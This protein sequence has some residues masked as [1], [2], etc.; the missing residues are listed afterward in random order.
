MSDRCDKCKFWQVHPIHLA[1]GECRRD[2]PSSP[3]DPGD[4]GEWE[5]TQADKWC[6]EFKAAGE[7]EPE[8]YLGPVMEG[9]VSTARRDANVI[10]VNCGLDM[11]APGCRIE[12]RVVKGEDGG[13]DE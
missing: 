9:I 8:K 10:A 3:E 12:M 6:G 11:P 5:T 7:E 4:F 13:C 2:T 1:Q